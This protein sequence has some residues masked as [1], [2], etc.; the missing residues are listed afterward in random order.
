[1]KTARFANPPFKAFTLIELL[2]VIAIIAIL[3]AILLPTLASAKRR[4]QEIQCA[5]NIR[6][7][8]L[9]L[10]IYGADADGY[11]PRDGTD[12][13][14]S[15][16]SYTGNTSS[17][18]PASAGSP[19]DPFAWF[20]VL[21]PAVGDRSLQTYYKSIKG[22]KYQNF[23][24]FPGNDIGKMWLCPAAQTVT[25]DNGLFLSGGQFGFF[26]YVM[27]LD[28][29]LLS[30]INNG[31][32]GNDFSYPAMPRITAIRSPVNVVM[33]TEFCFSPTLENWTGSS[34]PQ[35][36]CFPASRWT[37]F[38]KRHNNGGNLVFLD[39]H[40]QYY[41]FDYIYNPA[42]GRVELMNPDVWW[43]PNRDK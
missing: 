2:V 14:G 28:L 16:S 40:A 4:A 43:N 5:S 41:K 24:P 1:M 42:G 21:P 23:Y 36:G 8:G 10:G 19:N 15:Y 9:A 6:Q 32:I 25:A 7:W 27:N 13:G 39:G 18:Y 33:M 12:Q 31:V 37:Y 20:N 11:I 22:S 3:A 26:C 17:T 34:Q 30:S 29:K 35:M 38:V